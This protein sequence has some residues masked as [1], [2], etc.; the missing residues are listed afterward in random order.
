MEIRLTSHAL[1]R[2][3]ERGASESEIVNVLESGFSTPA[4]YGRL[5]KAKMFNYDHCRAGRWYSQK[6][7]EVYYAIE[8]DVVLVI[9]VYVFYG[10]WETTD[11]SPV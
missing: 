11:E 2:A 4:K 6:R 5:G 3:S 9:T 1:Q 7:V 10:E 8:G